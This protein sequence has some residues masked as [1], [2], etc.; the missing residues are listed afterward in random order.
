M[1]KAIEH[2]TASFT[3][4]TRRGDVVI[5]TRKHEPLPHGITEKALIRRAKQWAGFASARDV[6]TCDESGCTVYPVGE[7]TV[8]YIRFP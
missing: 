3:L 2:K 4:A 6:A 5:R 8:L 1:P 7:H